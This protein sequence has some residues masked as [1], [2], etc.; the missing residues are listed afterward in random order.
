MKSQSL[1]FFPRE[2]KLSNAEELFL[3]DFN[4]QNRERQANQRL[5]SFAVYILL[6][7]NISESDDA[8]YFIEYSQDNRQLLAR[9]IGTDNKFLHR[10]VWRCLERGLFDK[11][12]FEKYNILTSV[13]IQDKYFFGKQ[14]CSKMRV[15]VDYLYDFVYKNYENVLKKA[16]YVNK[17]GEIVNKNEQT[18][19]DEDQDENKNKEKDQTALALSLKKFKQA[20][21][22]KTVPE[23]Y[24][25]PS[26]VN[27]D[28]LIDAVNQS[29]Q[30][31]KICNNLDLK[32]LTE[33]QDRYDKIIRGDYKKFTPKQE[34]THEN[35]NYSQEELQSFY[36]NINDI[37]I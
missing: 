25:L 22:E 27:I 32:W 36:T 2:T 7:M 8:G 28:A 3:S 31:L 14:R 35:R 11:V 9:K 5:E 6:L 24:Q 37:E 4:I 19:Q 12:M 21:S 10:V 17:N 33:N 1:K 26:Y 13:D 23:N 18:T 15:I 34:P 20:F 29:P 16:I 30:F